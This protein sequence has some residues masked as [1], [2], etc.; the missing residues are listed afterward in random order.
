M[1]SASFRSLG[2]AVLAALLAALIPAL[3]AW[4]QDGPGY[5]V[6]SNDPNGLEIRFHGMPLRGV[7]A[8]DSQ[9]ALA[10][11]FQ[12]PVDST[13]FDRLAGDLPQWISMAY[14]NFDNGVIRS[15]RPVTFLT[16]AEN[17]G[18]SLRI[19]ARG[20]NGAP[21]AEAG[22]PQIRGSYSDYPRQQ[23]LY[24]P[25]PPYV[26]P[27]AAYAGFHAYGDYAPLR[28]YEAQELAVH[29]GDPMWQLAY[30][31]AIMQ[32]DSG[33]ATRNETNWYHGGDLMIATGLD[34]KLS[35]APGIAF[36]GSVQ[37]TNV[38]GKNVRL[39]SGA[40]ANTATDLVSG[41]GGFAFE[42]GRDSE[43]KLQA[44]QGNHVTGGK[45]T[46]YSGAPNGFGYIDV[47]YHAADLDTPTAIDN[48]ADTDRATL[49]YTQALGSGVWASLAGHYTRYGVHGDADVARTAGWDANL[50]WNAIGWGGL[51]GGISYDGHGEYRVSNDSRPG[52]APTPFVPLGIRDLENHAV[53]LNLSSTLGDGFW[54]S[55]Y[56]GW[57]T[58]RYASNGLLAGLDLHF[59][60][61]AGVD[62]ALGVRQSAV[63]WTEGER[64]RQ[65]TAGLNLTVGMG[66][67]PQPSWMQNAL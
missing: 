5:Q 54:F 49:G 15:P 51:L 11:D 47:A 45:L 50:R 18:F 22:P 37:Y 64:G 30:G 43:L 57:V 32:A 12:Q 58:D 63:S 65:L 7:H 42:L 48:R 40:I 16:R 13:A 60:P 9:N 56:A 24:P 33:I 55:A 52:A 20:P 19:M 2:F 23:Q 53:T 36:V 10:I 1:I 4:A 59:M 3:P 26:P 38:T 34:A 21:M 8:D 66:A 62:L 31:R 67:P 6:I 25:P 17:D 27:Q 14:A 39:A 61:A 35:F 28:A 46:L 29:R 44:S 41:E